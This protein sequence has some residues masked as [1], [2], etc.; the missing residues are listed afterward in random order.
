MAYSVAVE[1]V[2][3]C[4]LVT[5]HITFP[6]RVQCAAFPLTLLITAYLIIFICQMFNFYLFWK[7]FVINLTYSTCICVRIDH[8]VLE[9]IRLMLEEVYKF[10]RIN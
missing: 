5:Q 10:V 6:F 1:A 7:L 2:T 4:E 8:V 9:S 3:Y